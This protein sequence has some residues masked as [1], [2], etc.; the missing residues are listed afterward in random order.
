VAF[1]S[2]V[3]SARQ[4]VRTERSSDGT[5]GTGYPQIAMQ[6]GRL[7]TIVQVRRHRTRTASHLETPADRPVLGVRAVLDVTKW[8]K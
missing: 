6:I 4:M 5:R 1:H 2:R 8:G 3:R 7:H